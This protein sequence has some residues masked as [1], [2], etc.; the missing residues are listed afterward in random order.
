MRSED[1]FLAGGPT[2]AASRALLLREAAL[3]APRFGMARRSFMASAMGAL[4]AS[5][6]LAQL[7]HF[8]SEAEAQD[9]FEPPSEDCYAELLAAHASFTQTADSKALDWQIIQAAAEA[10]QAA[11]ADTVLNMLKAMN[12]LYAG[13]GI[14][15]LMHSLQ[16]A[17]RALRSQASDELVLVSLIHDAGEVVS[18]TNHAEVAAALLRP[19]VSDTGYYVTRTHM[20]FQLAHYGDKVLLPTDMRDR[21]K[22]EPWYG[23]AV[24]FC[25]GWDQNAFDPNYETLPLEEFEP[26]LREVLGRTPEERNRTAE[27]CL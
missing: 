19:Y 24:L 3:R 18:A 25:D 23:P 7:P 22:A 11:V 8:T 21:Y 16:T 20:E 14:S 2:Q 9:G 27:D 13:F 10:Q 1:Y 12:T 6:V 4:A 17:T 15:R 26:L 5:S